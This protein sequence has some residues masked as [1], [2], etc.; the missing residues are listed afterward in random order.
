M[1][2]EHLEDDTGERVDVGGRADRLPARLLGTHVRRRPQDAAGCRQKLRAVQRRGAARVCDAEVG[3]QRDAVGEE[4]VLRLDVA[5]DETVLMRVAQR[6]RDLAGEPQRFIQRQLPFA[7]EAGAQ[8]FPFDVGHHI[9]E[10]L[11]GRA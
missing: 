1:P 3:D 8:R 6:A 11:A 10:V 5:V 7:C 2:C 4:D 9:E